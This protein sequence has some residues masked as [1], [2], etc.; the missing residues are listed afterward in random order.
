MRKI[1]STLALAA[2]VVG[3]SSVTFGAT[4]KYYGVT[5]DD[6]PSGNTA[7]AFLAHPSP[8]SISQ[9][10]VLSTGGTGLGGG[11]F[12]APRIG[13]ESSAKCVFVTDAGSSDIATFAKPSYAK[14]GNYSNGSLNGAVY[15]IGV[16]VSPNGNYLYTAWSGS[17]NIATWTVNSDCSLTIGNIYSAA[18][19]VA[20][21]AI[22]SDGKVLIYSEPNNQAV[23]AYSVNGTTLSGFNSVPLSS[24]SA[25]SST[26]CYVTGIDMT[27]VSSGSSL[28]VLGNATLSGPY[29]VTVTETNG[30]L[31]SSSVTNNCLCSSGLANVESPL[32]SVGGLANN[33]I[34]YF[35]A[36]GYGTGYPA[37][38]AVTTIHNGTITYNSA[39][40]NSNA[41]YASNPATVTSSAT[42]N[43]I[44]Q[45]GYNGNTGANV[46]YVYKLSGTTLSAFANTTDAQGSGTY[47]LSMTSY[48]GR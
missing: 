8:A 26:G 7:T 1:L 44:W 6:N 37:G 40:V 25:C 34:L 18:D 14:V 19:Y 13:I 5:N 16:A 33:G 35:G 28:V 29:Y 10:K 36:A 21:L 48:P 45:M 41:Y 38:V 17:L 46:V 27:T 22:S 4:T 39:Y 9:A 23:D 20:P 32:F 42:G 31:N 30:T 3:L 47:V 11:Y 43:G 24:N 12:A 15:G 2:L